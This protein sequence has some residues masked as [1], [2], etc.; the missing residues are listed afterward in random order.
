MSTSGHK[1]ISVTGLRP[2]TNKP[3]KIIVTYIKSQALVDSQP[4]AIVSSID[5][6]HIN[7][8]TFNDCPIANSRIY[9]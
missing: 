6:P 3:E 8:C 5:C 1:T 7:I 2:I 4:Y 9:W